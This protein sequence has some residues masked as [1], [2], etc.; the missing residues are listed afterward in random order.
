MLPASCVICYKCTM[1]PGNTLHH[2][3]E[4]QHLLTNFHLSNAAKATLDSVKL[5]LLAAPTCSGRNTLIRGLLD[6]GQYHYI[7]SDTTRQPRIND[8]VREK[9]G[10]EY[11]FRTEEEMLTDLQLGR[12][13][14]AAIIHHQQVSGISMRELEKAYSQ[15]KIPVTDIEVVGV[16]SIM[17]LKPDAT[18]IFVLPPSFEEWQRRIHERGVME[19]AEFYRRLHSALKEFKM[20][21]SHDYYTFVIND[22]LATCIQTI[23][24]IAT[25]DKHDR[26]EEQKARNLAEELY[27]QTKTHIEDKA[28]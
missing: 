13:L 7:V 10:V 6:K 22:K 12:Y 23:H 27:Q 21:L 3:E 18:A 1:K 15:V 20:A 25:H 14:E 11:W 28:L 2:L 26:L 16:E 19:P 17:R 4:F 24:E 5:V 9:N 8:G